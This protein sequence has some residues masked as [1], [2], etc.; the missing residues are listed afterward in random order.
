MANLAHIRHKK[1]SIIRAVFS[2]AGLAC[3]TLSAHAK[4]IEGRV[5][6]CRE[7]AVGAIRRGGVGGDSGQILEAV[8]G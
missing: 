5:R 1:V 7:A 8:A 3:R 2:G 4:A 6:L